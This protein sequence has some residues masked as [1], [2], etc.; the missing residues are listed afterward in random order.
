MVISPMIIYILLFLFFA[1][2]VF[3]I[4]TLELRLKKVFRGSKVK[5]LEDLLRDMGKELDRAKVFRKQIVNYLEEVEE[6]LKKSVRKVKT[7]RFNPFENAG[8]NQSF[9]TS[10]LDEEGN[11]VVISTLYSREKVGVY[12]KPVKKYSSE[13]PLTEEESAIIE[14]SKK[15][16]PVNKIKP[17]EISG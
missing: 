13:Y 8:S 3:W 4:I 12:A 9:A 5:D 7:I 2:L 14:E 1:V 11:G 15:S 10:F 6:R 16:E 17:R